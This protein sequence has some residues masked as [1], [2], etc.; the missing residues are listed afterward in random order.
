MPLFEKLSGAFQKVFRD[1]RG[2]GKLSEK[3]IQD[4]LREV[5]LA[6]LEADVNFTVVKE[7][8]ARVREKA[9]GADVLESVSPGQQFI[10]HVHDELAALL[11]GTAREFD[12]SGGPATVMMIGLHG[13]GKT[14]TTSKLALRWKKSG[15]SVLLAACDIRRPAAVDQLR[16]LA[17]QVGVGILTPNPGETVPQIGARALAHARANKID[18]VVFDTG[19]RFQIDTEL[20]AE[21]KDLKAAVNPANVILVLDAAIGQESVHVAETFH[22]ELGIT[23]LI[24]TKLDGD[25][26][27]GAALSVQHVTGCPVLLVGVGERPEDLEVFHPDRMASRI[28]GMGDIVSLVEKAQSAIDEKSAMEMQEKLLSDDFT[29]ADFLDQL[30]AVK[31]LGSLDSLL[32]MMPGASNLPQHV[33]DNFGKDAGREMKRTEA[34]IQSMTA[35]ERRQP[36]LLNASRRRRI[37]AGSGTQVR[38]VNELIKRFEMARDMTKKM[39]KQRKKLLRFGR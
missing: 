37:A 16:I 27:G 25:A 18:V 36:G 7:F 13:S 24:L 39:K 32:E 3:N 29:L 34:I 1:L 38:D 9:M 10:K 22:K 17:N 8:I 20:V 2:Y 23:G 21:L 12:L 31:K 15:R 6:L 19:G 5:R 11:G 30:R 33:R 28:L 4:A 26:R 35:A 14:T